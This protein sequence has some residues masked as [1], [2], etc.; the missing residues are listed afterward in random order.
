M[1]IKSIKIWLLL[2]IFA[3]FVF[4]CGDDE[5]EADA[6]YDSTM[7]VEEDYVE[8]GEYLD[9]VVS[10]VCMWKAVSLKETPNSKG[11]YI[12][13]IY[14]GEV[15]TTNSE[16]VTDSSTSKVRD[17][18]KITLRDGT[19]GWIQE[20][21]MAINAEPYVVK[22]KTKVYKRPDILTAGK[23]DFDIMQFVVVTESQDDWSK[24]KGKRKADG[25]FTEG[26]V[27]STHLTSSEI[28]INVA[29]LAER[30]MNISDKEKKMDALNEIIDNSDLA[31]S[32]FIYDL[33]EI[34]ENLEM[35]SLE[36]EP[37]DDDV[38]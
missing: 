8:E 4:S 30:A 31:G 21:L 6:E 5:T 1:T 25:W 26:W 14:L 13:T 24:V 11:K 37:S 32:Q 36:E 38:Y 27:K 33:K 15:A 29:V 9:E 28:D 3:L 10:I 34:V 2:P 35:E 23:K 12:T 17:Y 7:V 22:S 18:V 20:N 19:E 16:I